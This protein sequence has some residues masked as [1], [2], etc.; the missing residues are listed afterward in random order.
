M[1]ALSNF[2][3]TVNGIVWGVPMLIAI[4]GTG[5]VLMVGLRLMPIL[6]LGTGFKLLWLG[7]IPDENKEGQISPFNGITVF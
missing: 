1:E 7:R 5:C 2:V 3:G 4:L 6:R